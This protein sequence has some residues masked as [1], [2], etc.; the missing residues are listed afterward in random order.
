[1]MKF[2]M[3]GMVI[4]T[5]AFMAI[6]LGAGTAFS[7]NI[8][9]K[10]SLSAKQ[11]TLSTI[12]TE[13]FQLIKPSCMP[14]HSNEGRDKPKSAVNFSVWEQY[15]PMEKKMLA[16]AI[17]GELQ[18]K[19][20]PPGRFIESHAEAALSEVQRGQIVQWCDSLKAKP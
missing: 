16:S 10:D 1:M 12:P 4:T 8:E 2:K 6:L 17:Q 13:V 11:D 3:T 14:C 18:K 5:G 9:K 19:S 7:Q 20:M 15:T